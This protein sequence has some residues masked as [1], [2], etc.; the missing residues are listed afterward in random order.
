MAALMNSPS[1]LS[2]CLPRWATPRSADRETLGGEVGALARQLGQPLMPWQQ[3]VADVGLEL[4]PE[5]GLPA[6]REIVVTVPRQ[7]GKTTLVL[8]W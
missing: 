5:S 4:D 1:S 8:G 3:L 7:S 6:Y 2:L